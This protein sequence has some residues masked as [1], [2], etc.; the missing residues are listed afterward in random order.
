MKTTTSW[1][2]IFCA[3]AI[4]ACAGT[5]GQQAA[6]DQDQELN[7]LLRELDAQNED[8]DNDPLVGIDEGQAASSDGLSP[9]ANCLLCLL[10][11]INDS[12]PLQG[13]MTADP[14]AQPDISQL[15]Y[16]NFIKK[17][18]KN[19]WRVVDGPAVEVLSEPYLTSKKVKEL[20]AG[21]SVIIHEV[22]GDYAKIA[23]HEYVI[24]SA[25]SPVAIGNP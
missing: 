5:A 7:D 17:L 4:S 3:A 10:D 12:E 9:D 23:D 1:L 20:H 16:I 24:L 21:D 2:A 18:A 19:A 15:D 13:F 8:R 11:A 6:I 22:V 25:L 14:N